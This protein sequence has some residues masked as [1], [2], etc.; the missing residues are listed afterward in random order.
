V[1]KAGIFL[2]GLEWDS[3]G[4][5][6]MKGR[7]PKVYY[8]FVLLFLLAISGLPSFARYGPEKISHFASASM[9]TP[10]D[11][12]RMTMTVAPTTINPNTIITAGSA[13]APFIMWSEYQGVGG[14]PFPNGTIDPLT[15]TTNWITHNSNYTVWMFNIKPGLKWS[16]GQNIT[17][18]DLL[19]SYSPRFLFN[20][21]YDILGMGREVENS[22]A[23]NSSTAVFVLNQ[24]D[25][26]WA[27]KMDATTVGQAIWPANIINQYGAAYPNLGT[28]V[29][30]G[31]FY[32]A[33]YSAGETEMTLLRN[34]Y[35]QPQPKICEIDMNF[36]ES[37][38][39]TATNLLSGS[40]DIAQV[41]YS[42]A[43]AILKSSNIQLYDAKGFFMTTLD[44]NITVYPYNMTAFR[45]ALAYGINQS[46][47]V[48]QAFN[49]YAETAYS[50][51][52][53]VPYGI[54]YNP[55]TMH[56]NFSQSTS[57]QLLDSIGITKGS[58][59][60]LHY[61]NGT[62]V[63]LNVWADT[64]T[65]ADVIAAQS[66]KT[67]LQNVGF[68]VNV[69]TSSIANIIG[70]YTS[71]VNNIAKTGI[72]LATTNAAS[73][74]WLL[75]DI[76]PGWAIYYAPAI[77]NISWEW[78]PSVQNEYNGNVSGIYSTTNQTVEKQYG[79]NIQ[80]ID[81]ANLPT[82]VLAYP[83]ELFG[84]NTQHWTNWPNPSSGQYLLLQGFPMSPESFVNLVPVSASSSTTQSSVLTSSNTTSSL[85]TSTIQTGS[86][87]SSN[88]SSTTI[89]TAGNST[90]LY[91]AIAIVVLVI[92]V[93]GVAALTFR[94]RGPRP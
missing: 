20:A 23:L 71:N 3:L 89:S 63:T 37:L 35:Y 38:S 40:T 27:D 67:D 60:L 81:A 11:T 42:N 62:V 7:F 50:G 72:I 70:D 80:A 88:T 5:S 92:V 22:Y 61:P 32:V 24:S 55:N 84:F 54:W 17:S 44:Y 43:P 29:V 56:Y 64:D 69:Q 58:D 73:F 13:A 87:S 85:T 33:N 93:G 90:V 65:T 53:T 82:I 77:P 9:C 15:L 83:D 41:E 14:Q 16:N 18:A 45:Q 86:T 39:Q 79:D 91:V 59:G 26:Q 2:N 30:F 28:D 31:P 1:P 25:A 6:K 47:I 8:V 57:V 78:P 46:A 48:A 21:S 49:G 76:L 66:M 34:P 10:Q 51:M 94:R 19:A 4:V 12:L 68:T 74:G 52:G 36:V 75:D